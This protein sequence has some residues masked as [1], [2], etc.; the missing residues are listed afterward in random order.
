[1]RYSVVA[2]ILAF[3]PAAL[4]GVE[5]IVS[6][7]DS[8]TDTGV[9]AGLTKNNGPSIP[10]NA[11]Y[12]GR[13]SNGPVWLD[14]IV[15]AK[16]L[17]VENFAAGGATTSDELVQG[18]VGGKFGEPLRKDGSIQKVPGADTQLKSYLWKQDWFKWDILYTI[19]V[20][21]NDKFDNDILGLG[22]NA[23]YFAAAQYDQW[24]TLVAF[25]AFQI[26]PIVLPKELDPFYALYGSTIDTLVAKFKKSFPWVKIAKYEVPV[27]AF[28]PTS[29]TP[30]LIPSP[31]LCCTDCFNGLPP[32]GNATVCSAPDTFLI[33]DGLHPST[34]VHKFIADDMTKFIQTTFGF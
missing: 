3:A 27:T 33:W 16:D 26:M 4:A 13:F 19:F 25:G 10:S 1:M 15:D 9:C 5:K 24:K 28:L 14:Y 32:K 34:K 23:S 2:A 17:E 22:K 21:A 11:Y 6:F 31:A 8:L 30:N 7:G 29:Y 20:G 18:W 12:K